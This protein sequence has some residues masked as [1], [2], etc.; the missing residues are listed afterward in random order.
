MP[1]TP[2]VPPDITETIPSVVSA[3]TVAALYQRT[4]ASYDVGIADLPFLMAPTDQTP[5]VRQTADSRKQQ[6]DT[7]NEPGEQSLNQWWVRSQDSWHKGAGIK[8]YEPGSVAETQNR[9]RKSVGLDIWTEGQITLLHKLNLPLTVTT[10]QDAYAT[11]AVVGGTNVAFLER[12]GVVSRWDGTTNTTFSASGGTPATEVAVA[13]A[14]ILVGT[15]QSILSG[16]ASGNALTALWTD[17]SGAI[18]TPYWV[19]SRIIATRGNK[20]YE[21]TLAGGVLPSALF[22]HPDTGWTWTGVAETPSAILVS[23][24]SNG[25]GAIYRLSLIADGTSAGSTPTLGSAEQ[26]AEFLPGET[27]HSIRVYLGNRVAI[28]TNRGIRVGIVS[29]N[30]SIQYGPLVIE[31]VNPVSALNGRDSFVY[32]GVAGEIDGFSGTAR[33]DL[34]QEIAD[35]TLRFAWTWDYQTHTTGTVSSVAFLGN[36]DRLVLGVRGEGLYLESTTVYEPSGYF[37][38]GKIRYATTIPKNFHGVQIRTDLETE[39]AVAVYVTDDDI[40][41]FVIRLTDAFNTDQDAD[42][43]SADTPRAD[44]ELKIVLEA[45]TAQEST[46]VLES[47]AV[48]ALPQPEVQR[49]IQIPLMCFDQEKDR[50]GV[51]VGVEG[52][53]WLRLQA[54]ETLEEDRSLVQIRDFVT[55]EAFRGWIQRIE[56]Q[57]TQ[58]SVRNAGNFGGRLSVTVLKL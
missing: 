15:D 31:T 1:L 58:P 4:G 23:G 10:G 5:Y 49:V 55:G 12:N 51:P 45:G 41:T 36:T 14:K 42:L 48:K 38:T 22:T 40:D 26:V 30:A 37:E 52:G 43:P 28:G 13:G 17:S 20:L 7:S 9:F 54:L 27:V 29:E 3:R 50:N 47:L 32:C 57:R 19:K 8:F 53:A 16:N 2:S 18:I 56:F 46:P 6:L 34:S 21:L 39:A 24:Y 33:I 25:Y 44:L 11:S 35:G